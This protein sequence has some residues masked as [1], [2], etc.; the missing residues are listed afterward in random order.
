MRISTTVVAFTFSL[1]TTS[2]NAHRNR[3]LTQ[4]R[5]IEVLTVRLA[6]LKSQ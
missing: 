3:S 1:I 5:K 2:A 4:D 6:E